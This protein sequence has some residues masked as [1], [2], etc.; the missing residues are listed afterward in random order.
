MRRVPLILASLRASVCIYGAT[1]PARAEAYPVCLA[2]GSVNTIECGYA[3]L[4]QC[5]ASAAG[6]WAT[7]LQAL[8]T[9]STPMRVT[10]GA[11]SE[12]TDRQ[13]S[14]ETCSRD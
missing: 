6:G 3:T 4:A 2:G 11:A 14:E 5:E 13:G 7:A 12:R 8:D 10:A 9:L 1:G